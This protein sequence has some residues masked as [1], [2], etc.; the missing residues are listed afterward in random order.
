MRTV[1]TGTRVLNFLADHFF[2][3]LLAFFSFHIRNWYVVYYHVKHFNFWYFFF[4]WEFL[5]YFLWDWVFARTP[6]KWLSH[7]RVVNLQGRR[8]AVGWI[9]VRSLVR[10]T[11]IDMFF[12]PFLNKPLHDQLSKTEV[13]DS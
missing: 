9:F 6:G 7:S 12:I 11:V 13:V 3:F 2:I 5:Y 4:G 1:G 10:L 8:A